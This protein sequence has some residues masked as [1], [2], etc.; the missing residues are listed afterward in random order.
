MDLAYKSLARRVL[1]VAFFVGV[2][3]IALAAAALITLNALHV[4][5]FSISGD[6]MEPTLHDRDSVVLRQAKTVEKGQLV[7]FALPNAWTYADRGGLRPSVVV[8]RIA[9]VPGD[10]LS[11]DG[12][13]FL[14]NGESVFNLQQNH[15]TCLK[16]EVGYTHTL[17]DNEIFVMGDNSGASL[18]SRRVFCDGQRDFYVAESLVADF[19]TIAFKF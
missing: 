5:F 4:S 14:V 8:K 16:G 13:N 17:T 12:K 3:A 2:T 11:Y 9:A 19:G 7:F 6:S 10:R 15:Y 18:D 1:R